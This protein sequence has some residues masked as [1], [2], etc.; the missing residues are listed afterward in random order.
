MTPRTS[1]WLTA[2]KALCVALYAAALGHLAGWLPD[3]V[4]PLA[5][6]LS[7]VFLALHALELPLFWGRV[8]RY[9]GPL[10]A[11]VVLTLLFGLLHLS[12]LR[13]AERA[14]G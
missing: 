5:P 3:G 1:P 9:R 11:S 4:L 14:G 6:V 10:A 13:G 2:G 12:P 7:A 8:K